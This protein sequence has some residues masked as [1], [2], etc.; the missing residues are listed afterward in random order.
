MK[1]IIKNI[2]EDRQE[3]FSFKPSG[4]YPNLKW[5]I[6]WK[7]VDWT[8][9]FYGSYKVVPALEK[10]LTYFLTVNPHLKTIALSD[11]NKDKQFL[12]K[13]S[14]YEFSNGM[15]YLLIVFTPSYN[16]FAHIT[17]SIRHRRWVNYTNRAFDEYVIESAPEPLLTCFK[18]EGQELV[19]EETFNIQFKAIVNSS[20]WKLF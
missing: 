17:Y 19:T 13:I 20:I 7:M 8:N 18:E 9:Y 12:P 4:P 3:T 11:D 14:T 10:F 2:L 16:S 1:E 15:G 6:G 5:S